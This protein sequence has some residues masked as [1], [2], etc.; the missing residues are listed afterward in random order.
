MC[1]DCSCRGPEFSTQYPC[2]AAHNNLWLYRDV[3]PLAT[4]WHA[5][6]TQIH[7]LKWFFKHKKLCIGN[8]DKLEYSIITHLLKCHNETNY[9]ICYLKILQKKTANKN[10]FLDD[11]QSIWN[12]LSNKQVL[13]TKLGCSMKSRQFSLF[14]TELENALICAVLSKDHL[15]L[16]LFVLFFKMGCLCVTAPAV[17]ELTLEIRLAL[18]SQKPNCLCWN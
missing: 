8:N 18:N 10:L 3:M 1:T 16:P 11:I 13:D 9:F 14:Q 15:I 2:Q 12:N 5:H 17:L 7:N 4:C 6:T